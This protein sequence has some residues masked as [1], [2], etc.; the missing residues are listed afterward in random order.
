MVIYGII[1]IWWVSRVGTPPVGA[2]LLYVPATLPALGTKCYT[3]NRCDMVHLRVWTD[4]QGLDSQ[5][6]QTEQHRRT[7]T[8][9][10]FPG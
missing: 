2:H 9:R 8:G 5:D 7:P 4:R 1:W 3:A 10:C 6:R